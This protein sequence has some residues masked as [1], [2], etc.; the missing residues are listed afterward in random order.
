VVYQRDWRN[1]G[2]M[3][4]RELKPDHGMLFLYPEAQGRS[5]WMLNCLMD[6]SA[7]Y[8]AADWTVTDPIVTMRHPARASDGPDTTRPRTWDQLGDEADRLHGSGAPA[9]YVLEMDAG[10]YA[11]HGIKPGTK[12]T[13]GPV[14]LEY[15]RRAVE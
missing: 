13:P 15:L 1:R 6:I 3:W 10:W 8:V 5:F 4:R 7:A 12:I 2:L 14:I 11:R 9:R